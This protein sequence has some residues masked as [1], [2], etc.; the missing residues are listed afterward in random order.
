M[1][2]LGPAKWST[3]ND[4]TLKQGKCCRKHDSVFPRNTKP[5]IFKKFDKDKQKTAISIELVLSLK[6]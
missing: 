2:C 4:P 5:K 3:E 6:V 1:M